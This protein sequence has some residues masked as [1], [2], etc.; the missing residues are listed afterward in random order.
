MRLMYI[1]YPANQIEKT[2]D[3]RRRA[4]AFVTD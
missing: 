4:S 1:K 2:E 3:F